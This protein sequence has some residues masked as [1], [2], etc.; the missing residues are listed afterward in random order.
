MHPDDA[1]NYLIRQACEAGFAHVR[2]VTVRQTPR[3]AAYDAWLSAGHQADMHWM[4][5]GRDDRAEPARRVPGVQTALVIAVDHAHRRPSD[6]GGLTGMVAR[7]AWGRDYHNV[8]GK[9]LRKLVKRLRGQ[10]IGAWGGVDTAAILERAWAEASGLGFV[11]KNTL[12]IRP[13]TTSWSV[14]GV[15]FVDMVA[16]ADQPI[17][18]DHCGRCTRCLV[19]CP[20]QA[21]PSPWTLDA[22]RCIAYWTIESRDLPPRRLRPGFGRWVFGCDVCQEVCPHNHTPPD[23]VE[24]AFAPRNAWLDLPEL[25]KTPDDALIER[26]TGTPLRRPGAV[27]LK[28]N[29]AIVLGNIGRA[30]G[31]EPLQRYGLTHSSPVVRASAVWALW[32]LG[33]PPGSPD[34]DPLVRSE[35]E[36][37]R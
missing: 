20:T 9:R 1:R 10:G 25:L 27:G 31:I 26:F 35:Q 19:A 4:V 8:V 16:T 30:E 13:G 3:I 7:Y 6:P 36:A 29:A 23:P 17:E 15:V 28:R 24:D 5:R 2:L 37:A 21:F 34:P 32:R 14:L 18:R 33:V 22:R 12:L 11:G